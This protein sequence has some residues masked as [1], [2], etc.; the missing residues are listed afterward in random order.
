MPFSSL[1]KS[2]LPQ[3][4]IGIVVVFAIFIAFFE[5]IAQSSL[6]YFSL[7]RDKR[8]N[9]YVAIGVLGYIMV[10]LLLLTS[11]EY[12]DMGHMNMTWSCVSIITAYVMGF[13]LFEEHVNNY[14]IIS[15]AL[16]LS[17]IYVGQISDIVEGS[18]DQIENVESSCND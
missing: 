13:L 18:G 2:C 12:E 16:A 3:S 15:I 7:D 4:P 5:A 11:Y 9:F 17:A 1:M 10:S 14:T 6:K 8:S